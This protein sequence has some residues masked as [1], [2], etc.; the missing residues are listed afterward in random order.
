MLTAFDRL[1]STTNIFQRIPEVC[2]LAGQKPNSTLLRIDS[3]SA[4]NTPKTK[5]LKSYSHHY[6]HPISFPKMV[7][8]TFPLTINIPIAIPII[9]ILLTI[10]SLFTTHALAAPT[11][12]SDGAIAGIVVGGVLAALVIGFLLFWLGF[13]CRVGYLALQNLY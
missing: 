4:P 1:H 3:N 8:R 6:I 2:S 12:L 13:F 9:L 11:H 10:L 5:Q 7:P